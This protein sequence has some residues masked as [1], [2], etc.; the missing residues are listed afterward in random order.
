VTPVAASNSTTFTWDANGTTAPIPVM[1]AEIG[2][3]PA[4]GGWQRQTRHGLMEKRAIFG[5]GTPGNYLVD[6]GSG[7]IIASNMV[8]IPPVTR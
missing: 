2:H 5:A 3:P 7:S 6:L 8:S 1:V 4:N